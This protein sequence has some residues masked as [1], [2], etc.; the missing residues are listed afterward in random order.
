M[1]NSSWIREYEENL[2]IHKFFYLMGTLK[3]GKEGTNIYQVSTIH[4]HFA[5]YQL[6]HWFLKIILLFNEKP[7]LLEKSFSFTAKLR[8][9]YIDYS[10]TH[11]YT[12]SSI[13]TIAQQNGTFVTIEPILIH[14]YHPKSIVYIRVYAR[15]CTFYGFE[16]IYIICTHHYGNLQNHAL[17]SPCASSL[18]FCL[19]SPW[20]LLIFLF[21]L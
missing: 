18:Y 12:A 11:K 15:F 8:G 5:L 17:K 2:R 19:F 9:T 4:K 6:S 13:I 3:I 7:L 20:Q 14:K 10:D 16:Q 1:Q 21:Y